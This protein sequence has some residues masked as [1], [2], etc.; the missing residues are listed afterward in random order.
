[1]IYKENQIHIDD[2]S[3]LKI[4]KV[5][6]WAI[7][8]DYGDRHFLLHEDSFEDEENYRCALY[9]RTVDNNGYYSVTWLNSCR[10]YGSMRLGDYIKLPN[11]KALR[12]E[13]DN[14]NVV[15][16]QI[17]KEYFVLGL[18]KEDLVVSHYSV[19]L[20]EERIL[21]LMKE[22]QK[23]IDE[24]PANASSYKV[25]LNQD[26]I[27]FCVEKLQELRPSYSVIEQEI[28]FTESHIEQLENEI[29]KKQE[30]LLNEYDKLQELKDK[31]VKEFE[32]E[33]EI[34]IENEMERD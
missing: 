4:T 8:F 22:N 12:F 33:I 3:L 26:C 20:L 10:G 9:E 5:K 7:F 2:V 25:K 31:L 29:S 21:H 32:Q 28:K 27:E 1:M 6:N 17:D 30:E 14:V 23:V 16:N 15:Y 19:S 34:E 11:N 13:N 18:T 24:N